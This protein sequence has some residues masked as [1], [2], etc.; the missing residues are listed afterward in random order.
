MSTITTFALKLFIMFLSIG[1]VI[2][3]PIKEIDP[4]I[5]LL[6]ELPIFQI[7]NNVYLVPTINSMRNAPAPSPPPSPLYVHNDDHILKR[8]DTDIMYTEQ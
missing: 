3:A 2:S 6:P 5:A 1:S 7:N 4:F 8:Y